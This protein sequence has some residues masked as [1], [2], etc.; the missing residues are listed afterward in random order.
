M[1]KYHTFEN[2][3]LSLFANFALILYANMLRLVSNHARVM[4]N[5]GAQTNVNSH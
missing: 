3:Y 5:L 2:N 1:H 4:Q